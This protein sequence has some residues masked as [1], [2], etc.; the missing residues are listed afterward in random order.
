MKQLNKY[1]VVSDIHGEYD[2]L[3]QGL[4][5]AGF[6]QNNPQHKLISVGDAFD[7]GPH[8]RKIYNFFREVHAI[9]V[10]GNHDVMFQ[11]YL[12]KGMDGEFV[13]FNILHNGLGNTIKSFTGLQD[14]QFSI[15][16]LE[17]ARNHMQ[18]FR[19]VRDWIQ[20]LPL[21]YETQNF[22]FVHAGL[23]PYLS[24]WKD[25][26]EHYMLWDIKDSHR[27]CH[28]IRKVVVIGHHHAFRVRENGKAE[29][30]GDTR[31][32]DISI[33]SNYREENGNIRTIRLKSYGNT[34]E[35]RPYISGNK[36]AIDGCTNLTGKVNVLVF[37]DY[38]MDPEPE[39]KPEP[40][41]RPDDGSIRVEGTWG[42]GNYSYTVNP[43]MFYTTYTRAGF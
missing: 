16:N 4:Q 40:E 8:S 33:S 36:I 24:N 7:R 13:L 26:D 30:M 12:E 25:T 18:D 42:T 39:K 29:G 19:S 11:E 15:P 41:I 17:S 37:E 6:D 5:E 3:R 38:D 1:F 23:N 34:D 21:Y 31:L 27:P 10:K 2:A 20:N 32:E 28:N 22:I 9:C 14:D 43:E 35:N